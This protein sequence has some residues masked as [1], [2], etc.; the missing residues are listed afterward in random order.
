MAGR[1]LPQGIGLEAVNEIVSLHAQTF[2][3]AHL[4]ERTRAIFFTQLNTQFFAGGRRQRDHFITE[5][6][7]RFSTHLRHNS[8]HATR[9]NLLG[10][11]LSRID[12]VIDL[13]AAAEIG[14]WNFW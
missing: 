7:A 6:D 9:D 13:N 1:D 8:R 11:R 12:N 5:M 10:V 3:S 14:P 2:A 4:D